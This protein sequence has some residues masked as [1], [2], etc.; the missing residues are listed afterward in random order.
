MC[1]AL[2]GG[3][4]GLK[5]KTPEKVE[6]SWIWLDWLCLGV[7][8]TKAVGGLGG[9]WQVISWDLSVSWDCCFFHHLPLLLA[10]QPG[11]VWALGTGRGSGTNPELARGQWWPA[12]ICWQIKMCQDFSV[13]GKDLALGPAV[14][15]QSPHEEGTE[16]GQ[17]LQRVVLWSCPKSPG[18]SDQE[19]G[20]A[21][22]LLRDTVPRVQL[23][24][25]GGRKW[26]EK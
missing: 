21:L 4:A 15:K 25:P 23:D 13:S 9:G 20:T 16:R 22:L 5:G 3:T 2:G 12:G 11:A 24:Y 10:S 7:I 1:P 8:L 14:I 18:R 17:G 26:Y 19:W 6:L